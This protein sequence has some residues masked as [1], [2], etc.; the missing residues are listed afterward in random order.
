MLDLPQKVSLPTSALTTIKQLVTNLCNK[1]YD[2]S[3][4]NHIWSVISRVEVLNTL[5]SMYC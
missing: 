5:R 2:N 3:G 4:V 1:V